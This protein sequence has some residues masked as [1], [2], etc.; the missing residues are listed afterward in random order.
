MSQCSNPVC[1]GRVLDE[2]SASRLELAPS[3]AA[4]P[5]KGAARDVWNHRTLFPE[6]LFKEPRSRESVL[7]IPLYTHIHTHTHTHKHKHAR[8]TPP[9]SSH[10]GPEAGTITKEFRQRIIMEKII[11]RS[12]KEPRELRRF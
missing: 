9:S 12:P 2:E 6:L 7:H 5:G 4:V 8:A 10:N 11:T 3:I 1:Y